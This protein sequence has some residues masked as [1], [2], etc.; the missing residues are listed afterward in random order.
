MG[1]ENEAAI[2]EALQRD[3]G[4]PRLEAVMI[5]VSAPGAAA[6]EA[7]KYLKQWTKPEK[8]PGSIATYPSKPEIVSEP[9]GVVLII[10]PWNFPYMLALEPMVG[11]IAAGNAIVLKPS[12]VSPSTSAILA[13]LIP[14]YLDQDAI[15]VVEGGV[16]E[17]SALLEQQWDLI[18]YTGN[19]TVGRIIAA[20]AA[21]HLT[22]T[23][24]E[25]GGKSPVIVDSTADLDV[26]ARR[27]AYGRW[28]N[29]GQACIAPDYVLA[30]KSIVPQ[31]VEKLKKTLVDFYGEDPKSSKD[32]S[33]IINQKQFKRLAAYLDAPE[34]SSKVVH[35]GVHDESSLYMAPTVVQ[36]VPFD[37]AVMQE[38]IFGP[39]L[40]VQTVR[41]VDDA[42]DIINERPKPLALYVFT[43]DKDVQRRVIEGTSAGGMTVNDTI[44][45]VAV[46]SLPFGGVGESG[47]G[48]YHGKHSFDCFSHKK[49]V[50]LRDFGGDIAA[51]FP[52]V[53]PQKERFFNDLL[54]GN[55]VG[56]VLGMVGLR[57]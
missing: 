14:E 23:I 12:E 16:P 13:K 7:A 48:A 24:L 22:P 38:E 33:R 37:S 43:K 35:G 39:I 57:K 6:L 1:A 28:M 42:I 3:L 49:G 9:L 5:D 44:L 27:I 29:N 19:G 2:V 8:V 53:T 21:K 11:A 50:L 17:T 36:D 46:K 40:V 56:L 32:L 26:T 30:E 20:A 41:N 52:P 34:V 31:L 45:H 4:K 55:I 18:F 25:L 10:A 51:R 15:H 47:M 54:K